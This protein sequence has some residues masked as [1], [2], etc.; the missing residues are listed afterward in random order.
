MEHSP[1]LSTTAGQQQDCLNSFPTRFH[2]EAKPAVP[3]VSSCS[4]PVTSADTYVAFNHSYS[5]RTYTRKPSS[6]AAASK[7]K[8]TAEFLLEKIREHEATVSSLRGRLESAQGE[9][10]Q[11]RERVCEW[12]AKTSE[13]R[14]CLQQTNEVLDFRTLS[15]MPSVEVRVKQEVFED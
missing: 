7:I 9:L 13:L 6:Q 3:A 2:D 15:Q 11:L 8:T 4:E 14:E 1:T 10:A 5:N 12:D